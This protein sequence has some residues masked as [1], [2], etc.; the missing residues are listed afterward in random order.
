MRWGVWGGAAAVLFALGCGDDA[1]GTAARMDYAAVGEDF[2]AAPFP[3]EARRG[4]EGIDVAAFPNTTR[5][6]IVD[7]L[8]E[9]V[10]EEEGFATT[11]TLYFAFD[12]PLDPAVQ[13]EPEETTT[14]DAP[15]LLLAFDDPDAAPHP[16]EVRFREDGGPFGAP[17]LLSL[18]PLQGVPLAPNTRYVAV[19][20]QRVRDAEGRPLAVAPAVR[21]LRRG[22]TP[23]G[24]GEAAGD[25]G[26]AL[27]ALA[28]RGVDDVAAL[29]VFRTADPLA[30]M[31]ALR[32]GMLAQPLPELAAPLALLETHEDF[33]V[34]RGEL[35]MPVFQRGE[36]P[37]SSEGG[38]ILF[39]GGAPVLQGTETAR[40]L[41]TIPRR[42]E[43]EGGYPLV[44][45]SRT[46]GGG[47]RPLVDRGF[48]DESGEPVEPGTGPARE[49]ARVG[50]AGIS[51]DGPHGGLRNITGGDEQLLIFNI[52]NPR[53]LRDNIRQS[54]AE[55]I[56]AAE[57]AETL[58]VD[59]SACPGAE[60]PA[61]FDRS[62][63]A[64]M[65]HSMG[66][67]I[68]PLAAA[69]EPRF[70][71]LLLSGAG[72]SWIEN[73]I[74][75]ESPVRV[76]P[77][78]ELQLRV[79]GRYDLHEHD[80]ALALLQWAGE[81]AD[82]PVFGAELRALGTHVLMMQGIVDTYIL[83]PI[84][85]ASSLAFGL[86]LGGPPLDASEPRLESF[87]PLA[88]RLPLVG[89]GPVDL[90]ASGNREG[91][92]AI[93]TQHLEGPI[94]DGH[95]VVFQTEGPKAEYRCFLET[96][97]RDEPPVVPSPEGCP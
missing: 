54:A 52:T 49:F 23:E 6:A 62:R 75:K 48:R 56:L 86:D 60:G 21:T 92:T 58:E 71:A 97:A 74:H 87:V 67:T 19:V 65:G 8:K 88:S 37:Y 25:H 7:A 84:A 32:E 69:L 1:P 20:R 73:V 85:N 13:A 36:P 45:F 12:A 4:P 68:S 81:G 44:V 30:A 29:S 83:P 79:A 78:A 55:L 57:L 93:V 38:D 72:G 10:A 26:E 2:W 35:P 59:A 50:W 76:K 42:P 15:V 89:R 33:C 47:D 34:F 77:F 63:F 46:G 27:A 22:G 18:L 61:R 90:P 64:L 95:E 39:E 11:A 82:P 43:P 9:L 91:V 96:L 80:P 16:I 53:A 70:R 41:V 5:A 40:V 66:A 3:S 31:R 51:I 17:N 94:E 14:L 24:M 28:E